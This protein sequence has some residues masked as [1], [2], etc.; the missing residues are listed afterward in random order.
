[1]EHH[2]LQGKVVLVTGAGRGIGRAEALALAE[3]G[4]RVV[5]NDL[6]TA[7]DGTGHDV[8]VAGEVVQEIERAG[9]EAIANTDDMADHEGAGRAVQDA[10][11][12]WGRL[13]AVVNNAGFDRGGRTVDELPVEDW[14]AVVRVHLR[15]TFCTIQHACRHWRACA[16]AS[17]TKRTSGRIVN[18]VSE[19]GTTSAAPGR[20]A[21]AASKGAIAALTRVVAL[22]MEP[23]GVT[24]NAVS[25]GARTR[26]SS[27]LLSSASAATEPA[28]S[29]DPVHVGPAVV[30]LVS[31][32]AQWVTGQVIS[33]ARGR[34][35]LV[36]P[37]GR[38]PTLRKDRV[39]TPD[40]VGRGMRDLFGSRVPDLREELDRE[41][42][43]RLGR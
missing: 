38:G 36:E 15:H 23:I 2:L 17:P 30:W 28:D 41:Q 27:A 6:G 8:S 4:A 20:S 26:R 18:T 25:P 29:L 5:V 24:C 39:W 21:Y 12:A 19:L 43:R 31:D 11:D 7:V 40:E 35:G 37:W 33:A 14:D 1:M 13:D 9:G 34:L 32:D 10:L 3:H 22:E 42:H 16:S